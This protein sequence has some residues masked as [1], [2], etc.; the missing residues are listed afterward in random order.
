M[1]M[2]DLEGRVALVT[3]A[4]GGIGRAICSRFG[5]ESIDVIAADIDEEPLPAQIL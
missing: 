4:A 3:G 1:E 2:R 5:E